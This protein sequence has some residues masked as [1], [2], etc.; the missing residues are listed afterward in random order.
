MMQSQPLRARLNRLQHR[1]LI[2]GAGGVAL[3]VLEVFLNP[4]QFFR[5]Y[6][7]AYLFWL[8]I[9]LGCL[10]IV[11]LHHLVRGAWGAVI[12]RLLE[13][14]SRTLPLMALLFVP[15]LFGLHDL[16][17]WARPAAVASDELLQHK[18]PYLNIPFF[19]LRLVGY[20]V[21]WIAVAHFLNRWSL[22]HDR[23]PDWPTG[24]PLRRRLQMLSG[25]GL[26][27]YGLS[28]T[29][30]A[31]DWMM[32][33]EPHWYSTIFGMTFVIGQALAALAFVIVAL[34]LVLDCEPFASVVSQTHIHDLGNLLLAF[35]MLWAYIAFSQFLIIWSGNLPEEIPWYLHRTQG[36]W[37]WIGLLVL[38]FHFALPFLLLL[39]RGTKRRVRLLSAVAGGLV[40][41][42]FFGLYWL[43]MPA[44]HP[45]KLYVHWLDLVAPIAVGGLWLACF[46]WHLQR[47]EMLPL[48]APHLQ[49]VADHG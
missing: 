46:L 33:L 43:V 9:A 35:V 26:V 8:G 21:A 23:I 13:S 49:R 48:H 4:V 2:A 30:A 10:A 24:R 22:Q 11:M 1:A 15:L 31:V 27:L 34:A 17:S 3:C 28:A 29:F 39:S 19:V 5:S 42:G 45:G 44:F 12:Q 32:S 41:M 36:G 40:V 14:G 37:Q 47:R 16:Y 18:S 38:V 6:L 7:L 20:F 25:P